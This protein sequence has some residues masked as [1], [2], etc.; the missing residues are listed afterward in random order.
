MILSKRAL[1]VILAAMS[2]MS[3]TSTGCGGKK[4]GKRGAIGKDGVNKATPGGEETGG[5]GGVQQLSTE[6]GA[7]LDKELK[8]VASAFTLIEDDSKLIEKSA[9]KKG[10]YN[11]VGISSLFSYQGEKETLK[12]FS[13][14]GFKSTYDANEKKYKD[15]SL[16]RLEGESNS[17]VA[18]TM[19][20][21]D[22]GLKL[23]LP[24]VFLVQKDGEWAA[25]HADATNILV[26]SQFASVEK[27]IVDQF[28]SGTGDEVLKAS[29]LNILAE[30]TAG[31]NG[32][33]ELVDGNTTLQVALAQAKDNENTIRI[34]VYADEK[35]E[36]GETVRSRALSLTYQKE[37]TDGGSE[38]PAD[39]E[40]KADDQAGMGLK[41]EDY[42][43]H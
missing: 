33:I 2:V 6:E 34:L 36:D 19:N 30:G 20:D 9:L 41:L 39:S 5:D 42:E 24:M 18:G 37:G 27:G 12:A 28:L 3:I 17:H 7:A 15:I 40:K 23:D 43:G 32:R 29:V 26:R 13:N 14:S 11:L 22:E 25:S 38:K 35:G 10:T 8:A 4:A 21:A 16:A 31:E 1:I